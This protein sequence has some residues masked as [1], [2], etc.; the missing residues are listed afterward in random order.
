M[1]N[2]KIFLN[3][4]SY[5]ILLNFLY[6]L[7]FPLAAFALTSGPSQPEVQS[8]EPVGTTEMVDLSTGDFN[9]NIPLLDIEGYPINIAYHAGITMDQEASWVGLGWNINPGS[10]NRN[11]RGLPDDFC[12]VG[13]DA[14]IIRK[15]HSTLAMHSLGITNGIGFEIL[16]KKLPEPLSAEIDISLGVN[17]N[18]YK[19]VG[20]ELGITPAISAG[21]IGDDQLSLQLGLSANSQDGMGFE[22]TLTYDYVSVKNSSKSS[23]EHTIFTKGSLTT[24]LSVSTEFNSRSGMKDLKWGIS[25]R[26]K[27]DRQKVIFNKNAIKKEDR[28]KKEP[29]KT[30]LSPN[31]SYGSSISFGA[32]TYPSSITLPTVTT[33]AS[34]YATA[35]T[36][37]KTTHPNITLSGYE[38]T[39]DL[40]IPWSEKNAFGYLYTHLKDNDN[41]LL[42][43]N[44]EGEGVFSENTAQLPL[45]NYTYDLYS[46]TGQGISGQYRPYRS[47]IN[48]LHDDRGLNTSSSNSFGVKG[49]FASDSHFG[50]KSSTNTTEGSSG[51]WTEGNDLW[52]LFGYSSDYSM[53]ATNANPTYEPAYFKNIGELTPF[54]EEFYSIFGNDLLVSPKIQETVVS[55]DGD[56]IG[57]TVIAEAKFQQLPNAS[58]PSGIINVQGG[59][60]NNVRKKRDVRNQFI[61]YLDGH[62]AKKAAL[63]KKINSVQQANQVGNQSVSSFAR[64]SA[65]RKDH[66]LS[67]IIA[68]NPDGMRYVYGIPAY[69]LEQ[70]EYSFSVNEDHNIVDN[71]LGLCIYE[72]QGNHADNS[73]HNNKKFENY[74]SKVKMPGYAH[75][76][77]L[78]SVLSADY[79][80][81]TGN[82]I[83]YE[84]DLGTAIKINYD[85]THQ[86]FEWRTPIGV[87][88]TSS[89]TA[90]YNQGFINDKYDDKA[91]YVHGKK[92]IWYVTSIETRNYIAEFSL[93]DREDGLGATDNGTKV[94]D[95]KLKKID[96][97]VLYAREDRI[98]N[99]QNAVP[100]KVIHFEYDYSL[101]PNV[102]N[103][104][105][106]AV[107]KNGQSLSGSAASDPNLNVNMVKG[108]LTLKKIYFTYGKSNKAALSPYQF[109]YSS[110]NPSYFPKAYDRWGSYRENKT[111]STSDIPN[112]EFPYVYQGV[113]RTI[114]DENSSAWSLT[115][116][117][118]PSGGVLN[119]SYEADDYA[120]VQ[121]RRTM[122]MVKL[123][124]AGYLANTTNGVEPHIFDE[125]YSNSENHYECLFFD[126]GGVEAVK[127]K[128]IKSYF[129]DENQ[130]FMELLNFTAMVDLKGD[131]QHFEYVRGYVEI[132]K[133][134]VLP[135]VG[136]VQYNNGIET[137]PIG[138]VKI[139][140]VGIGDK[141]N[142]NKQVNS[143]AKTAWQFARL[144]KPQWVYPGSNPNQT[145]ESAIRGLL[146][147]MTEVTTLYKSFN[148]TLE[149]RGY[150]KH[151]RP[152]KSWIRLYSPFHKKIG[153]GHRVKKLS[154][155][156]SWKEMTG[157]NENRVS[158]EFGQE[159]SYLSTETIGG[160]DKEMSSGVA[161][162][163]PYIGNDEN[164]WRM[165]IFHD[166]EN[167]MAPDD[168]YYAETPFGESFFPSA[169]VVYSKVEVKNIKPSS[170]ITKNGTGKIVHEFYTARDYPTLVGSSD[171]HKERNKA[172]RIL[173]TDAED[174]L[175]ASQGYLVELND[176]HGKPK[177]QWIFAEGMNSIQSGIEYLYKSKR[178]KFPN[179]LD[180][181]V[182]VFDKNTNTVFEEKEIGTEIDFYMD[183]R[184]SKRSSI[185]GGVQLTTDIV[186]FGVVPP[187]PCPMVWPSHASQRT[188]FRSICATKVV[189]RFGVLQ[190]TIAYENGA[191]IE[192]ENILFDSETGGVLLTLT[193][194][195]FKDNI[196]SFNY[197]AHF[198][199]E[200]MGQAYKNIGSNFVNISSNAQ[201]ISIS[202][203]ADNNPEKYFFPG[204]EILIQWDFFPGM[205][206]SPKSFKK[207]WIHRSD[208][209]GQLIVINEKGNLIQ[210]PINAGRTVKIIRS[211]RR[212]LQ[213]FSIGQISSL[214]SPIVTN[215]N[216]KEISYNSGTGVINTVAHTFSE[217]WGMN[218]SPA[219]KT[220]C[221]EIETVPY[222]ATIQEMISDVFNDFDLFNNDEPILYYPATSISSTSGHFKTQLDNLCPGQGAYKWK[223]QQSEVDL[224][225][226]INRYTWEVTLCKETSP[227]NYCCLPAT[228]SPCG[229]FSFKFDYEGAT[230]PEFDQF[231]FP[232]NDN[233]VEVSDGPVINNQTSSYYRFNFYLRI[234]GSSPEEF[235]MG[236]WSN[237]TDE[238][239]RPEMILCKNCVTN[240]SAVQFNSTIVNPYL[241]GL[242]GNWRPKKE[243]LYDGKRK[244]SAQLNSR[245]DGTYETF[246][247]FWTK[248]SNTNFW[249]SNETSPWV[250]TNMVSQY[251]AFGNE[252]ENK[253][254]LDRYSAA[255]YTK[256]NLPIAISSNARLRQIANDNFEDSPYELDGCIIDHW[257][258]KKNQ[259]NAAKQ[260]GAH[261]HTGKMSFKVDMSTTHEVSRNTYTPPQISCDRSEMSYVLK[262]CDCIDIF[263]P[264]TKK[265]Y[266]FSGWVKDGIGIHEYSFNAPY[267]EI[268]FFKNIN[269]V[270]VEQ[271]PKITVNGSGAIIEGWQRMES[272]FEIP[273]STSVISVRLKA[274]SMHAAWFD[275]LR[276]HP[277]NANLKSFVY[278]P[279]SLKLVAELDENNF[280]TFYEYD[281]EGALA[282]V[283]KETAKGIVTIKSSRS[284]SVK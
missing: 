65:H 130:H 55:S 15:E 21:K 34:L 240:C 192:T 91:S 35:G 171:I 96:K 225:N 231:Y 204:D 252:L 11:M 253:D 234:K 174:Y 230:K 16:G 10:I 72:D 110:K 29:T 12:G 136:V 71:D 86:D 165:P 176:M 187:I 264:D 276:I 104:S 133:N 205:A 270:N 227:D 134:G 19:G 212:N 103:N 105:G 89:K 129:V 13:E 66:H 274:G 188:R 269:N 259:T 125:L 70:S 58:N 172:K 184:E 56:F 120:F 106:F 199:Y 7:F 159:Y 50:A 218:C 168:K 43:F 156:D 59:S 152:E 236:K 249:V 26:Y 61:Q 64:V 216:K 107:N 215:Q 2:K 219:L 25:A 267:V 79:V 221:S 53:L 173:P 145:G 51:A 181:R 147:A 90:F 245:F 28:V 42:D 31:I 82:G 132:K 170:S 223:V 63:D 124:G 14:D 279:I 242:R 163:E 95:K 241:A 98:K 17:Y 201:G 150:A 9:Y 149:N 113:S 250:W 148:R 206:N 18:N 112:A 255:I 195:E 251:S 93:S 36:A 77:L 190:K 84:D 191:K 49:G 214:Y 256:T 141:E 193:Q 118:L 32:A 265:K 180:N 217:I 164:P 222:S 281:Q 210:I 261:A 160:E 166:V 275:D 54:E 138:Y 139:K 196:F 203:T 143:I 87:K 6:E 257:S 177:A 189:N 278:D 88:N 178:Q 101:C 155:S 44:R 254:A 127:Q 202:G 140:T 208:D 239:K 280:A 268:A 144:Q 62:H 233:F 282:R 185:S 60:S 3:R 30:S 48:I 273:E 284:S 182:S 197:P 167:L 97:I 258:F 57:N 213:N 40:L 23:N 117:K 232:L 22:P 67:E 247:P 194:N 37:I 226:N 45:A 186:L 119:V 248:S 158:S 74:F 179:K 135:D 114:Q 111:T 169:N 142:A 24:S 277:F 243:F 235:Y 121:H 92:E 207:G 5:F 262:P 115:Q 161:S 108:K 146:G 122:Q 81:V 237:S 102:P 8:F 209:N 38:S 27:E 157:S 85:L 260:D 263:N 39:Q 109:N 68:T 123:L 128:V 76:F 266:V 47:D 200:G 46:V 272:T 78:T 41:V 99:K 244:Y 175:T 83:T 183:S 75:S 116:I 151:F 126:L 283:K 4:I 228:V 198:A 69:N 137:R 154:I 153:G 271:T 131:Q 211:G 80:D 224:G 52:A 33:N 238:F 1:K 246:S 73:I 229:G 100:I 94:T 20:F 162:Y 220:T